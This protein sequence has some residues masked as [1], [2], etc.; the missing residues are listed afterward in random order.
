MGADT[1]TEDGSLTAKAAGNLG[2]AA[3]PRIKAEAERAALMEKCE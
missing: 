1:C 2:S 3:S